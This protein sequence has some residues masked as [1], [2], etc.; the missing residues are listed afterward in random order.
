MFRSLKTQYYDLVSDRIQVPKDDLTE[1]E[2]KIIEL[3]FELLEEKLEGIP[4]VKAE[5]ARSEAKVVSEAGA[6]ES[7]LAPPE[8]PAR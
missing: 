5:A 8:S 7:R 3:G 2:S 6:S 1:N 4:Y